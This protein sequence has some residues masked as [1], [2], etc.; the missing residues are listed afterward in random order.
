MIISCA[1]AMVPAETLTDKARLLREWGF[2]GMAVFMEWDQFTPEVE[3]EL[4]GLEA[5]TGIKPVEFVLQDDVY[6]HAMDEDPVLRD[7]CRR[8]YRESARVCSALGAYVEIE[9]AY[10]PQIP[11][12]LFD[13]YRKMTADQEESFLEFYR[14]MLAVVEGSAGGILI[15]PINRYESPFMNSVADSMDIVT[16]VN[17][18][19]AG[20]LPDTFHM[21]IEEASIP[22]ALRAGGNLVRHVHLGD[23]NRLLPGHGSLDWPG[24]FDALT[25]IGYT[26]AVN[27]EC[28]TMGEPAVTLP[29][30][31]AYLQELIDGAQKASGSRA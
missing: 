14:E 2:G 5:S 4:L 23:N 9:Y 30:T 21:S 7:A 18:P 22:D 6:G 3:H 25:E 27:L 10:G 19:H 16:K 1:S 20:L 8:M 28:S 17:H 29:R 15:E 12:P 11:L 13:P 24:I 31:A 26:G